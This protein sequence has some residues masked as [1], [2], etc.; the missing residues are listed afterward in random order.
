MPMLNSKKHTEQKIQTI[1]NMLIFSRLFGDS[2]IETACLEQIESLVKLN[3]LISLG[4]VF[5]L[6]G[7]I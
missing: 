1:E 6:G 3:S 2:H 7:G 5:G 4:E